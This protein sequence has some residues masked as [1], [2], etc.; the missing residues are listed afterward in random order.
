MFWDKYVFFF[1]D[2]YFREK[3]FSLGFP[4]KCFLGTMVCWRHFSLVLVQVQA[5]A[6]ELQNI[7]EK[8]INMLILTADMTVKIFH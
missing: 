1:W 2:K 4:D 5:L 3:W 6:T 7:C 8:K